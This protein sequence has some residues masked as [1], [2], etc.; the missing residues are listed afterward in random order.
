MQETRAR[1]LDAVGGGP[2]T[3]PTLAEELGVSRAAVWNHVEALREEG[4]GI[5]DTG[6]GY[7]LTSLPEYGGAAIEYATDADVD[8]EF[9]EELGSTNA[10]ARELATDGADGT[11]VVAERQTGGQGRLDREWDSPAGGIYASLVRRPDVPP[12]HAPAYTLAAAV[13]V[14][15]AARDAGV[16]AGI[17][18]PNDVLVEQ[19]DGS[20]RKLCGILTEMEGEADRISWLVV[21]PGVNANVP[22]DALPEGA[23]SVLAEAEPV[24]RREFLATV[25]DRFEALTDDL[26]A[27]LPAWRERALTLGREVRVETPDGT[28]E[29]TAT[30]VEFPGTLVVETAD[31]PVRVAAGDC[32]HLRPR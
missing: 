32:E 20:A 5:A 23:T 2:V 14:T 15:D 11:V 13:A 1:V 31:G 25:V 21:G 24:I 28:V 26:D 19:P 27:V 6:D 3:G 7:E 12:A 4:F 18:W 30:D 8:V 17:K 9:H 22:A 10:R 16:D 29:G